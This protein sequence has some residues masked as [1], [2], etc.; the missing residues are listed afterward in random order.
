MLLSLLITL[1]V[2]LVV[3]VASGRLA[4]KYVTNVTTAFGISEF[5]VAFVIL[6]LATSMPE[7]FVVVSSSLKGASA[8]VLSI[9]FGSNIANITLIIGLTAIFSGG[10]SLKAF[11][12]RRN[13]VASG[14][15]TILPLLFVAN[16][17]ISR[18]EGWIL[19]AVFVAY[20]IYLLRDQRTYS[21]ERLPRHVLRGFS[22]IVVALVMIAVLIIA[23]NQT[24]DSAVG[25]AELIGI[26]TFLVGLL[27]LSIGTSLPELITTLH[28]NR[29][30]SGA[31]AMG[32]VIGSNIANSSLIL[33]VAS[34]ISPIQTDLHPTLLMT[35]FF[36]A[37]SVLV[38]G[39]FA[40]RKEDL[41]IREGFGLVG[42][43]IVFGILIV[44]TGL[45]S[46]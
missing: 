19:I 38:M 2:A 20:L 22:S 29:S 3:L 12:L 1:L 23:A 41:S 15:I 10:V 17:V 31:M 16:G 25:L 27:I 18:A 11:N 6:A 43:F 35:M 5:T 33:G 14:V 13:I 24:V 42:L 21:K 26:P 32:N 45:Q 30:G 39:V 8:I 28:S 34:I 36:V 9:V 44:G 7:L 40:M 46:F 4:I 37:L